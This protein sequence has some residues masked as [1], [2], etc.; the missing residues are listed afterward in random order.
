MADLLRPLARGLR[1]ARPTV[2][3]P[4]RETAD[5]FHVSIPTAAAAYGRLEA[6]GLLMSRRGAMTMVPSRLSA[7]RRAVR[8]VVGVPV[9]TPGFVRF[10]DWR[11]FVAGLDEAVRRHGFVADLIFYRQ[12]EEVRPDFIDRVLKHRSDVLVW[13]EP[14]PADRETLQR[15]EDAGVSLAVVS[16]Q[17]A[18]GPWRRYFMDRSAGLRQGM[19]QWWTAGIREVLVPGDGPGTPAVAAAIQQAAR[20]QPRA[21]SSLLGQDVGAVLAALDGATDTAVFFD[22]DFLFSRLCQYAP[23]GLADLFRHRRVAVTR[24]IDASRKELGDAWV[25]TL[26][27]DLAGLAM[28]IGDDIA[29][30]RHRHRDLVT[31]ETPWRSRVPAMDL[32]A[33]FGLE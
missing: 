10:R 13:F 32:A 15:L 4:L 17:P 24:V 31:I 2:F 20:P 3:Y 33:H 19:Q 26:I 27:P 11:I 6:E 30:E 22:D 16:E 18:K 7:S 8:G 29:M 5:F 21:V 12:G 1:A 14:A 28:R 25:D 23:R 9:W